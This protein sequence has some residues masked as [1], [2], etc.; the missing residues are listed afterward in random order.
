MSSFQ[1]RRTRI[2]ETLAAEK[3]DLLLVFT[4][5]NLYYLTGFTV[6]HAPVCAMIP[7]D[8]K[9]LLV[10]GRS[11]ALSSDEYEVRKYPDDTLVQ[12]YN[13][14]DEMCVA[15]ETILEEMSLPNGRIAF[16]GASVPGK[17][18]PL[19]GRFK[20]ADISSHLAE[21][22]RV[23]DDDE[24]LE[25]RAVVALADFAQEFAQLEA[26][27]GMPEIDL[28]SALQAAVQSHAG[29]P[30]QLQGDLLS[31]KRT[32]LMGGAPSTKEFKIGDA[33]IVDLQLSP[34]RYW[35]DTTRTFSLGKPADELRHIFDTVAEALDL[36]IRAAK[37][38]V[39]AN[40]VDKATREYITREGYGDNFP[41][42]T[43]HGC[44]LRYYEPPLIV[45]HNTETLAEGMV[46]CLE[47]GVYVA[48][49]GGVRL[50]Q[51]VLLR[52]AGAETLS[53]APIR[54]IGRKA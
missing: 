33:V 50:E 43:G 17:L 7:A 48:G 54:L 37:P 27:P 4:P 5:E 14:T 3:I 34:A 26:R 31:G 2:Q 36:A 24:M 13:A 40:E 39:P 11:E 52:S 47:P 41:H 53:R 9:P 35:A 32:L 51:M 18:V 22:R 28:F 21:M 25:I 38:G 15:A 29:H 20:T 42:H 49:V 6:G 46:L 44:G 8:G 23:K 10:T 1:T 19:A 45:P 12:P 30:L 16:E